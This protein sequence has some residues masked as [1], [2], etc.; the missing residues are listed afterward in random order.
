LKRG[1]TRWGEPRILVIVRGHIADLLEAVP[2]LRALRESHPQGHITVMANEYTRGLLDDCPYVDEVVYAF[3]YKPRSRFKRLREIG[4]VVA[5]IVGRYDIAICLR[6]TPPPVVG[7]AAISGARTRVGFDQPRIW[8]SLLTHNPGDQPENVPNREVNLTPLNA[9]GIKGRPEYEPLTWVGQG[10]VDSAERLLAEE[11]VDP[12]AT[13]YAVYQISAN[14]GCNE[15]RT[16]K[17]AVVMDA[18]H[19]THGLRPVIVGSD[20]PFE[21]MKYEAIRARTTVAPISLLGRTTLP[22]AFE[23]IRRASLAVMT[24]SALGQV[25]IAQRTPSVIM[26]GV[27]PLVNTAPLETERDWV[28]VIQHWDR[29]TADPPN[30]NC[31]FGQSYC[32]SEHCRENSSLVRTTVEEITAKV[33]TV[34]GAPAGGARSVTALAPAEPVSLT[35]REP[36]GAPGPAP[37]HNELDAGKP[38]KV[39]IGL[40]VYNGEPYLTEAIDSILAQTFT[41]F[42]L[43]I[44]DNA[45]T[46]KTEAICRSYAE[47]DPRIRYVR[48]ARNIGGANNENQTFL[49][50]RGEYFRWAAHDDVLAPTLLE[51]CVEV[52][53]AN[54][55]VVLCHPWVIYIDEDGNETGRFARHR[56]PDL[57]TWR[58]F[59]DLTRLIGHCEETYGVMRSSALAA[60]GLQRNYT[61]SDRT[62]LAHLTLLGGFR[63]IDEYLFSKRFHAQGSTTAFGEWRFR[64]LWF[65]DEYAAKINLPHWSQFFHYLAV[66][67]GAPVSVWTKVR[68]WAF[69]FTVWI[70][71]YRKWRSLGKDLLLAVSSAGRRVTAR[72]DRRRPSTTP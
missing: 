63:E 59:I 35:L 47:R 12:S 11:G 20:D 62:L 55:S 9:V 69:M 29:A 40:A 44:S 1:A 19:Q 49:L 26:F 2:A 39:S 50:A 33:A 43:I 37:A 45:S 24:D 38:P 57:P 22:E 64:M 32:H 34:L 7:L 56:R 13:P 46:D 41:D 14:W 8:G 67:R 28:E 4:Q 16:D 72:L 58:L 48:N 54:P 66:I 17:W 21:L 68:C 61:D 27:E 42:E 15:L 60:T 51:R 10:V 5:S 18:V 70:A 52:L 6:S 3:A 53:D 30:P 65:G 23:V 25:A 31:Q 36:T 71:T